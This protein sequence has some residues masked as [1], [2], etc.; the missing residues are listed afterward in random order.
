MSLLDLR[1][2]IE[3]GDDNENGED[4]NLFEVDIDRSI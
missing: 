3:V 4:V 1:M 2:F